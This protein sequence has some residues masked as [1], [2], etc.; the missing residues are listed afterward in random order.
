[1]NVKLHKIFVLTLALL[2]GVVFGYKDTN[3]QSNPICPIN[4]ICSPVPAQP[5]GCPIGYTCTVVTDGT[6]KTISSRLDPM[7]PMS[8]TVLYNVG[9]Q[10][11]LGI[12]SIKSNNTPSTLRNIKFDIITSGGKLANEVLSDIIIDNYSTSSVQL[13]MSVDTNKSL[14]AD[15]FVTVSIYGHIKPGVPDGTKLYLRLTPS[16]DSIMAFDSLNRQVPVQASSSIVTGTITLASSTLPYVSDTSSNIQIVDNGTQAPN[17][18]IF[19]FGFTVNNI[20]NKDI[21]I[22]KAGEKSFGIA[23]SQNTSYAFSSMN[24]A[25]PQSIPGDTAQLFIIP[26][27]SYR[28]FTSYGTIKDINGIQALRFIAIKKIFITDLT[29]VI[30]YTIENG[31]EKLV[32]PSVFVK[33]DQKN[34]LANNSGFISQLTGAVIDSIGLLFGMNR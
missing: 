13:H 3:A 34:T 27:G 29:G 11:N 15:S 21:Y 33:I 25:N 17:Q 7:S 4:Y 1:M 24:S 5:T 32:T 30:V 20:S 28:K 19:T 23:L 2:L 12:F 31:L 10:V 9:S 14:S 22:N 8:R 26:A 18:A 6:A 16:N